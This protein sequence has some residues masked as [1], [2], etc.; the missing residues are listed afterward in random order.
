MYAKI[1]LA[2][3]TA[4]IS[5]STYAKNT[6][7]SYTP[8]S[9]INV[10]SDISYGKDTD[11]TLDIYV[12][13][14]AKGAPVIFMIHGGAWR[15][16]DKTN[17]AEFENKVAYW[18]A[19]GFVFIS[20]NYRTLPK[21]EPVEQVKDISTALLFAQHNAST[22][23]GSADRFILMGHSAGAHLVA[24]A[25]SQYNALTKKGI[26]PWLG[27]V[28]MDTSAYDIVKRMTSSNPSEFYR[29]I[30][31]E[32]Y[33]DW[34]KASP[35]HSMTNKLPPFLAICSRRSEFACY[36]AKHFIKKAKSFGTYGEVLAVDLSHGEI[37]SELGK[38]SCYT[39]S[40][41]D[42]FKKLSPSIKSMLA[43]HDT[44]MQKNCSSS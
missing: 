41:N 30:F 2:L 33:L 14:G 20:S 5:F 28:S 18:V 29:A 3:L 40:V 21:I 11:Q 37:N 25:S 4:S 24:L 19:K 27:T 31:G 10:L 32:T 44:Q 36:Q 39:S 6:S 12:P 7:N 1:L 15:G 42:F 9:G 16:G 35:F 43:V 38:E 8:P 34:Q 17:S 23:G 13:S 26:K 22:W